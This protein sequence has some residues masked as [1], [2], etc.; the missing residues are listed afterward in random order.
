MLLTMTMGIEERV[1]IGMTNW[2]RSYVLCKSIGI[3]LKF[4]SPTHLNIPSDNFCKNEC[5]HF[6][7]RNIT[8]SAANAAT[9]C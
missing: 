3:Y 9:A 5:I 6:F 7:G 2:N 8:V 4:A 1:D